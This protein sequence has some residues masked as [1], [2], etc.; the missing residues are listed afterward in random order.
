MYLPMWS[1]VSMA[2]LTVPMDFCKRNERVTVLHFY[3]DFTKIV[4]F[5]CIFSITFILDVT[6][7]E[8]KAV[9]DYTK[10]AAAGRSS[11]Y[12]GASFQFV[13]SMGWLLMSKSQ[14]NVG[15]RRPPEAT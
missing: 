11:I 2:G 14:G 10:K 4:I 13:I 12:G 15:W 5:L 9:C 1:V 7:T 6:G 8:E 3:N